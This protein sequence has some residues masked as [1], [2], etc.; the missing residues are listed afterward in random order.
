MFRT[1]VTF[2]AGL[3]AL[4]VLPFGLTAQQRFKAGLVA[5]VNAS[6]INGDNTGGYN[7]LGLLGGLRVITVL[8]EKSDV[9]IELA[10]SQRGSKNDKSEPVDIRIDLNYIEVPVLYTY[11]DWLDESGDYY[12][13]QALGGLAFSRLLKGTVEDSAS[14]PKEITGDLRS[15]DLSLVLGVEFFFTKH[16]SLS[17]RWHSSL[18]KLATAEKSPT[19]IDLRGYFFTFRVNYIF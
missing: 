4:L 12:K 1:N 11:K 2:V 19:K 9:S 3:F 6:Q 7:K 14:P 8:S 17:G 13:V 5:G 15:N 16:W 18:N 10:Y